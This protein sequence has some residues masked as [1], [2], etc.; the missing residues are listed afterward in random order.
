MAVRI[1]A[2]AARLTQHSLSQKDH[3]QTIMI[4]NV[5]NSPE[6]HHTRLVLVWGAPANNLLHEYVKST[7]PV[8]CLA[9]GLQ[10]HSLRQEWQDPQASL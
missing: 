9:W 5:M 6:L 3:A 2:G 8:R 4:C 10:A 7:N 1:V